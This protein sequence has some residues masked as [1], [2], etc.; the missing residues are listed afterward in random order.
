MARG[1][2][3]YGTGRR[4]E[5]NRTE[6]YRSIDV[7]RFAREAMLGP[8]S[9][10]WTWRDPLTQEALAS[11]RVEGGVSAIRLHFQ[12]NGRP[13]DTRVAIDRTP[14]G[15]GGK[16]PWFLC[17]MCGQRAALLYAGN[18]GFACR[19][20]HGLA[21]SIQSATELTTAWRRHHKVA[22]KLG[23]GFERPKGMHFTT[24]ASLQERAHASILAVVAGADACTGRIEEALRRIGLS[25]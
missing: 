23:P 14:C 8:G 16:R 25:A 5:H 10:T 13:F 19:C 11:I 18:S 2:F 24:C 3:R 21:Y 12:A 1:G 15:F 4:R 7:R 9:W 17:P 6:D 22:R 20:C